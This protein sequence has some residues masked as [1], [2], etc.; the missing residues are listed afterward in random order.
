[1]TPPRGI[2]EGGALAIVL[3]T[4]MPYVHGYGTW[5]FGEE[6][7]WEVYASSYLAISRLAKQAPLTVSLTPVVGDQL[8][9]PGAAG[10][11]RDFIDRVRRG[12][13]EEDRSWLARG[14]LRAELAA[15]EYSW[16][17]HEH[18]LAELDAIGD[19]LVAPL[20]EVS[21][22]TSAASHA[23]LP[24]LATEAGVRLQVGSGIQSHLR[25]TGRWGGGLWLPEC[26]WDPELEA[27]LVDEGVRSVCIEL[28]G[29][30][31]ALVAP[32]RTP[33]GLRIIP[34]DRQ[35]IDLVWHHTGYPSHDDYRS[36]HARSYQN[37]PLWANR[38]EGYDAE[39]G[40]RRAEADARA[41]ARACAQRVAGGKAAF[42]AFDTELF[43]HWWHEGPAFLE[44]AVA[45]LADEGVELVQAD[46]LLDRIGDDLPVADAPPASTWGTG[47]DL[48]T[49]TGPAVATIAWELRRAELQLLAGREPGQ[50]GDAALRDLLA[51]QSSDWAFMVTEERAAPY[52]WQRFADHRH[53]VGLPSGPLPSSAPRLR[54]L[55][56]DLARDALAV[57]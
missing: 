50:P 12:S 13:H 37:V 53:A 46:E 8:E 4:H 39:I 26:A 47:R 14:E 7:L 5:P 43:G 41:W 23:V 48:R 44:A 30:D 15:A 36:S 52:G 31:D 56:P 1:M 10:R 19:A 34:I 49:W 2:G 27:V 38:G 35:L 3:H 40:R 45:A 9:A 33:G 57:G 54:H 42:V 28:T 24:L 32:W 22:W 16:S 17:V 6:W 21:T 29:Q 20:A 55:A 51:L 25:R 18:W 11:C